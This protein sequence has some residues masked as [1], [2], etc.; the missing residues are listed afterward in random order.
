MRND[1]KTRYGEWCLVAGAAEGLGEAYSTAL[2]EKGMNLI[3]VDLQKNRLDSLASK[4]ESTFGIQAIILNIDLAS[5]DSV[6]VM[7]EA[8]SKTRC[9]LMIYNA[10]FSRVQK[11]QNN[12]PEMLDR[13]IQV[14]TRTPIQLTHAFCQFY[15]GS[16]DHKKGILLMSSLAGSWGTQFLAPY[17][18]TK[19]FNQILA[20][21]LH[22]ELKKEGFDV[23][24]C[25]AGA[26]S[27]PAYLASLP[28][29]KRKSRSTMTPEAVANSALSALGRRPFVIPGIKNKLTYF[30]LTRILPRRISLHIMNQ[31]VG[32]MYEAY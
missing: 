24:A 32:S 5:M 30:L 26:T 13:Y 19:A 6:E 21:S 11:F 4:L 14:N 2:A 15:K 20:E 16:T 12:D 9:R 27:T 28:L 23:L 25:V 29:E 22:Y 3:M 31:A 1:L 17:G 8:I 18:G 10:A 7:M